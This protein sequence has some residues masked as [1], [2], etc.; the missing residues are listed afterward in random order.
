MRGGLL[1]PAIG[2]RDRDPS[3]ARTWTAVPGV[4]DRSVP[5]DGSALLPRQRTSPIAKPW[6]GIVDQGPPHGLPA[7]RPRSRRR[8]RT[9]HLRSLRGWSPSSGVPKR[10]DLSWPRVSPGPGSPQGR[11]RASSPFPALAAHTRWG[12]SPPRRSAACLQAAAL[13]SGS[14]VSS[15]WMGH[16]ASLAG[17]RRTLRSLAV[18]LSS[19]GVYSRWLGRA[20]RWLV[21]S[22][23]V[24]PCRAGAVPLAAPAEP[25]AAPS[26]PEGHDDRVAARPCGGSEG[27]SPRPLR[28][29]PSRSPTRRGDVRSSGSAPPA[30]N[31]ADVEG[32]APPGARRARLPLPVSQVQV[33]A[34]AAP[35]EAGRRT[36]QVPARRP[37]PGRGEG[38]SSRWHHHLDHACSFKIGRA[39]V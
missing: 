21:P 3:P 10:Q 34:F 19:V 39:H 22:R 5:L 16:H 15:R 9:P 14:V 32:P 6:A 24:V 35:A 29:S 8:C 20:A 27:L 28:V 36:D 33:P 4:A 30:G 31:P 1:G 17:P 37:N 18:D 38:G 11:R 12:S 25:C 13:A 23:S 2:A 7:A 26:H